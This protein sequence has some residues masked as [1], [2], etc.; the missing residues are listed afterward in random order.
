MIFG[1]KKPVQMGPPWGMGPPVEMVATVPLQNM[2]QS[3]MIEARQSPGFGLARIFLADAIDNRAERIMLDF[4]AQTLAF[5]YQIDGVWHNMGPLVP[6]PPP[7]KHKGPLPMGPPT[8]EMGD[9]ALFVL[10]KTANLKPEDRRSKQEGKFRTEFMGNKFETSVVSQ[11]TQA[12]ERVLVSFVPIIKGGGVRTLEELGM[13]DKLRDQVKE[14]I[15]PGTKGMFIACAMPQDGLSSLWAGVLRSTDRLMRDFVCLQDQDNPEPEVENIEI[16]KCNF[17]EG[18]T[19]DIRLPKILLRQPEVLLAPNVP[20]AETIDAYCKQA[21]AEEPKLT[22]ISHRGKDA[23]D[24]LLRVL[25]MAGDKEQFAK[26]VTGVVYTRLIRK[27]CE[28]CREPIQPTPQLLQ[29]L[30]IPQGRV[31]V[32]FREKQP[33]PPLPPGVPPPEPPKLKKGEPPPPPLICPACRGLGFK[34][35]TGLFELLVVDDNMRAALLSDPRPETIRQLARQAGNRTLQEEGILL[36]AMGGT[37]LT[38]LQ[39]VLKQ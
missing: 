10:K 18:E 31:S 22:L 25:A 7:P 38:E 21:L 33:P 15:G 9:L 23:V 11:G 29:R 32:L 39:R 6:Y 17:A 27:L 12:G 14:L 2:A 4:T 5:R 24:G 30:G 8:R 1:S 20:N 35:R 28:I 26:S 19:P 16:M 13:R 3:L 34:G 36:L 37:S